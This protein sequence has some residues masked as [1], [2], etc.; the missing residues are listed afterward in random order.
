V[1]TRWFEDYPEHGIA[2]LIP[3]VLAKPG[4]TRAASERALRLLAAA[5]HR[6]RILT[7]TATGSP[8]V[9]AGVSAVLEADPL[10]N[11]PAKIP[12][13]P[14]WCLPAT[15]APIVVANGSGKLS[16]SAV[17]HVVTM[18]QISTIDEPYVGVE[19]LQAHVTP[20]SLEAFS[21]SVFQTWASSGYPKDG[22]WAIAQLGLIGGDNA[23]RKLSPLVRVWP[24]EAAHARAVTGLDVLAAIGSD[25][26]LMHLNRIS[27]TAKFKGLK[28]NAQQRI[29]LIAE[30]RGLTREQLADL[31]VPDL[32]LDEDGSLLL[33]FGPRK[34][35]V[36][37]DELLAAV[38]KDES[39]AVL[40]ALPKPN[41]KDD[42][43]LAKAAGDRWKALKKDA[44]EASKI[45]MRRIELAM[46]LRR[47]WD[48][49]TFTMV[50]VNHPLMFHVVRRLV[51]AI[52]D[53]DGQVVSTF[54]VAE[55][56]TFADANDDTATLPA[57]TEENGL[58][59]GIVHPLQLDEATLGAW[60]N[61]F[62]D[63]E[64]LQPFAQLG[65]ERHALTEAEKSQTKLERFTDIRCHF[66]K[67]LSME[68]KGWERGS[69]QDAGVVHAMYKPL[70]DGRWVELQLSEGLWVGMMSETPEQNLGAIAVVNDR[71]AW[72]KTAIRLDSVDPIEM[73]EVLR[74]LEMMR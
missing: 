38:V 7:V 25:V 28:E 63:Y 46:S 52:F 18:L 14:S 67:I 19:M 31:L 51:W 59:I 16:D 58:Q 53:K 47:R 20:A 42:P 44:T 24:G 48:F 69:P 21:W 36:G 22:G 60:G 12:S 30:A 41:S 3:E 65:R 74:D 70:G 45:Q 62:S 49:E 37:F 15:L 29:A 64:I 5:G 68:Y 66:G 17:N 54:R 50:F 35:R 23:A 13:A 39:G 73:S 72:E 71:D 27:E 11:L 43:E 32:G 56:R 57:M 55:D 40:R 6:E 8:E 10:D 9:V 33:D 4:K 34:F 61:V 26:S 2:G 1:A